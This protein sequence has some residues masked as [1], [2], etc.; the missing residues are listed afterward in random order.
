MCVCLVGLSVCFSVFMLGCAQL[1]G[2]PSPASS[3]GC[4]RDARPQTQK[5]TMPQKGSQQSTGTPE[6]KTGTGTTYGG[7]GVL[8]DINRTCIKVKC[9][10]CGK[11]SHFKH[12]C[13][14]G[15]KTREEA[16]Q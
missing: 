8:M 9:F 3:T 13:S 14:D 16:M 11:P 7:Q 10:R 4:I 1:H 6:K 2:C 15:P 5:T 12:D